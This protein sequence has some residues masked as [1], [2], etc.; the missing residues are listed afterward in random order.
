MIVKS[1]LFMLTV[2]VTFFGPKTS[3]LGVSQISSCSLTK[4][5]CTSYCALP[6][7]E[8]RIVMFCDCLKP[9]PIIYTFVFPVRGPKFGFILKIA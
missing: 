8:K 3:K 7:A 6:P 2:T 4:V 1:P 9:S 5:P